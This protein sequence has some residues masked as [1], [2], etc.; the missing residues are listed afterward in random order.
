MLR[1]PFLRT[2]LPALVAGLTLGL[3]LPTKAAAPPVEITNAW[4][5]ATVDGQPT[6]TAFM[7][8][9]AHDPVTISGFESPV[10][11]TVQLHQMTMQGS[12]MKMRPLASIDL[13]AGESVILNPADKHV[14]LFGLKGQL[15]AGDHFPVTVVMRHAGGTIRATAEVEVRPL[16]SQ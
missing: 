13:K 4:A 2:A 8:I 12:T 7:T 6:G 1:R 14:M 10:A 15:R 11:Q 5:R 16:G 9:V 3:A